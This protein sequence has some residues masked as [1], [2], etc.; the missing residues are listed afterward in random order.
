M[1]LPSIIGS[2]INLLLGLASIAGLGALILAGWSLR[3]ESAGANFQVGGSFLKYVLWAGIFLTLP[4]V[5]SWL[6]ANGVSVQQEMTG[7]PSGYMLQI[8]D[9]VETFVTDV[10]LDHLVPV[11]AAALVLKGI[12]DAAEGHV[13]VGAIVGCLF[14]LGVYGIYNHARQQWNDVSAYA[15]TN[16]LMNAWTYVATSICP[17]AAGLAVAGGILA[18]VRQQ[19]WAHYVACAFGLLSVTGLYALVKA[20]T[21]VNA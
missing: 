16:F 11:L 21:G 1:Q 5:F 4:G 19:R 13:P 17:I 2:V 6:N 9:V 10:V 12:L 3:Q 14:L 8:E 18:Y 20:M 15:T 7:H